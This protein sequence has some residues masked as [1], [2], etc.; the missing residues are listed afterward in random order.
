MED[1]PNVYSSI[2]KRLEKVIK[3]LP[4]N[5]DKNID[6]VQPIIFQKPQT[7][8]GKNKTEDVTLIVSI[9]RNFFTNDTIKKLL[10]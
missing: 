7:A 5:P 8:N 9:R 1:N 4:K 10:L 3:D 2:K 6:T